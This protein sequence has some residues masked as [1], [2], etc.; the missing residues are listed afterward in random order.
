MDSVDRKRILIDLHF[1]K[2]Q[3]SFINDQLDMLAKNITMI[4][5]TRVRIMSSTI[6]NSSL[7]FIQW[8]YSM[9][10]FDITTLM[11]LI[12]YLITLIYIKS[13]FHLF[14]LIFVNRL[15]RVTRIR[16]SFGWSCK[17]SSINTIRFITR[18]IIIIFNV[19]H[20]MVSWPMTFLRLFTLTFLS[21]T[22]LLQ[23]SESNKS[24]IV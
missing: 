6:I 8:R 24:I 17:L 5:N 7:Q 12:K 22:P 10:H 3:S 23:L 9:W 14:L 19:M 2:T 16:L 20:I 4:S 13:K 18:T 15:K 21:Q 1:L 11:Q